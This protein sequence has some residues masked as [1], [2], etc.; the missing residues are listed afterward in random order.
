MQLVANFTVPDAIKTVGRERT[1]GVDLSIMRI[2]NGEVSIWDF[3]G[4]LEYTV[5]HQLL[6]SSEVYTKTN[7]K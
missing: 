4:Q 5:T 2:A 7:N 3:G 1:V 6:L